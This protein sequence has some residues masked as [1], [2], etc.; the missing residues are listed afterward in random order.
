MILSSS[1]LAWALILGQ[2]S[3]IK[4]Q[5]FKREKKMKI[6]EADKLKTL[7]QWCCRGIS[8]SVKQLVDPNGIRSA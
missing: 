6:Y 7:I 2:R 8:P 1:L 4:I 3:K 5:E